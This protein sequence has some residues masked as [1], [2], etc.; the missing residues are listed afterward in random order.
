VDYWLPLQEIVFFKR[1]VYEKALHELEALLFPERE[2]CQPCL[3]RRP[4]H[5]SSRHS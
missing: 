2:R 1:R 5:Y 4:E 3:N